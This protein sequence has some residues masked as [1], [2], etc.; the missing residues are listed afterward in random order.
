MT[1]RGK[2]ETSKDK[3]K[4]SV[5]KEHITK[6]LK[7]ANHRRNATQKFTFTKFKETTTATGNVTCQ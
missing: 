5:R 2:L 4:R 1:E 7:L 3:E 6:T